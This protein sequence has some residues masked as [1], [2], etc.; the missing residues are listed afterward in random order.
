MVS[1]APGV[2]GAIVGEIADRSMGNY[3]SQLGGYVLSGTRMS[4]RQICT[5]AVGMNGKA[6]AEGRTFVY[7]LRL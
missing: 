3:M 2:S 4:G 5:T 7:H 6:A 1:R